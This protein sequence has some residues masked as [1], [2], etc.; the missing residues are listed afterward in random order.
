MHAISIGYMPCSNL[1]I[2]K[3]RGK[4]EEGQRDISKIQ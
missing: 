1:R 2:E 4:E 3:K